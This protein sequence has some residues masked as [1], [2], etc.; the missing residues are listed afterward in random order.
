MKSSVAWGSQPDLP[1]AINSHRL[2]LLKSPTG[3]AALMY[4]ALGDK[5]EK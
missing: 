2:L 4:K 3:A 1:P 5:R